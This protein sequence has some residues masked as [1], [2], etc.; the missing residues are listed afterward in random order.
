MYL[1][2]LKVTYIEP[3]IKNRN[4]ERDYV[5]YGVRSFLHDS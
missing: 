4:G 1:G 5:N 3:V 2:A